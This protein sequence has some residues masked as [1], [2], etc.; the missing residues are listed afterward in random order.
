MGSNGEGILDNTLHNMKNKLRE[1]SYQTRTETYKNLLDDLIKT[2]CQHKLQKSKYEEENLEN[3][4]RCQNCSDILHEP[5]TLQCGHT[6][7]KRCIKNRQSQSLIELCVVCGNKISKNL[8]WIFMKR[9]SVDSYKC[10]VA[11]SSILT[12]CFSD[13]TE[14]VRLRYEGNEYFL[15]EDHMN[16]MLKYKA[17]TAKCE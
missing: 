5:I 12:D 15:K 13:H 3:I 4:F 10:N 9:R 8:R 17:A 6:F 1:Y 2:L 7:C 14:A 11:L 16:A